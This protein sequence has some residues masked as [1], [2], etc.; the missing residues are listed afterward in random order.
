LIFGFVQLLAVPMCFLNAQEN[1]KEQA[2]KNPIVQPLNINAVQQDSN[3]STPKISQKP[4]PKFDLP[5]YVI[6]GVAAIDLPKLEKVWLD[7]TLNALG[8]ESESFKNSRRG[9]ETIKLELKN[10]MNADQAVTDKY[11]GLL[12]AGI[13]TYFTPQLGL[14]FGQTIS[15]FHYAFGGTYHLTKGY[16]QNTDQSGGGFSATGGTIINPNIQIFQGAELNGK[17]DY[18]SESY[19]FY[20]STTPDFQRTISDLQL[21]LDIENQKVDGFPYSAG[22]L[23]GNFNAVDSSLSASETRFDLHAQASLSIGSLPMQAKFRWISATGGLQLMDISGGVQNY[24]F[25]GMI[26]EG[27]LHFYWAQGSFGQN[28]VR[29]RPNLTAS[30]QMSARHRIYVAYKPMFLPMTLSSNT[31]VNRFL[32]MTSVVRQ[33]DITDAGEIGIESDWSGAI[34]TNVSFSVQSVR[35][36]TMYSD[37]L[38]RGVWMTAFGEHTTVVTLCGEVV[39]KLESND[40]FASNIILRYVNDSYWNKAI[41]YTPNIEGNFSAHHKFG[42]R[43]GAGVFMKFVGERKTDLNGDASLPKY[44]V[45]D[46]NGEYTPLNFLKVV[47]GM[48]NLTGSRYEI[49]KGY[50]EFPMTMHAALQIKW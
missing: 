40:Y 48:K 1:K 50:Q 16:T 31:Q 36:L 10:Q 22:I 30:Y 20:G 47:I 38:R 25:A 21:Q 7:D 37:S 18:K 6:T 42:R 13:G 12:H 29:L 4:L 26:F 39:A 24:Q 17:I 8:M 19:R 43:I 33:T 46:V 41:P 5:E 14:W 28:L 11:S 3:K 32:S 34:Q 49:W 9:R 27:F 44:I 15:D 23:I 2:K 45:I 35:D